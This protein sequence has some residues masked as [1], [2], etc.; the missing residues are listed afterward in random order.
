MKKIILD[1]YLVNGS[2]LIFHGKQ[3]ASFKDDILHSSLAAHLATEA[4]STA[5]SETW[6]FYKE[7]L[8][9][10]N[11]ITNSDHT[12]TLSLSEKSLLDIVFEA[13]SPTLSEDEQ[14]ALSVVCT[15][16]R[17]RPHDAD[18]IK[19]LTERFDSDAVC[20]SQETTNDTEQAKHCAVILTLIR[21]DK[22]IFTLRVAFKTTHA[23]DIK[24]LNEPVLQTIDDGEI[25]A[26]LLSS[27]L[28]EAFYKMMQQG[29]DEYIEE[30]LGKIIPIQTLPPAVEIA[31]TEN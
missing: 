10:F 17:E 5:P 16:L 28:D 21:E 4:V 3:D 8:S 23:L 11:W 26:W 19:A 12:R 13:S 7:N 2:I 18:V 14:E 6:S 24:L 20:V 31:L 27:T 30:D 15:L 29:I 9:N 22:T 1:P 25:N